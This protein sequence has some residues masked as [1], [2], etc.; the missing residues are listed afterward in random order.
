[1]ETKFVGNAE[2][3]IHLF[4]PLSSEKYE[5]YFHSTWNS[6]ESFSEHVKELDGKNA[7]HDS[8]W[9]KDDDDFYGTKT[10]S[11]A[12]DLALKGWPEGADKAQKVMDQIIALNPI[13]LKQVKYGIVGAVPN[14]P[15]AVSGNPLNMKIPDLTKASKRPIITLLSD[16]GAH[17]GVGSNEFL[18]RAAVVAALVDRIEAA[19]YCCDI[20]GFGVS[21]S[22]FWGSDNLVSQVSVLAKN[23]NQPVDLG[24][25]AYCLGHTAM[26]RRLMFA[27]WGGDKFNKGLTHSLGSHF[28]HKKE[29]LKEKK[30][31]V[32]D[33]AENGLFS[34]EKQAIS[35]GL[36]FF[37]N[38]LKE[39]GLDIF[40]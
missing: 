9:S 32:L 38:S 18:N 16:I 3:L 28:E 2:H 37:I 17:C 39:Q 20:I 4:P 10:L 8:A 19:G 31:Y 21:K 11:E 1:M 25:L 24:R 26:F 35:K 34:S 7:W 6:P 30:I 15:K 33:N 40:K 12:I 5:K 27:E 22:G 36:P 14:V 23:S 29:L 13:Q